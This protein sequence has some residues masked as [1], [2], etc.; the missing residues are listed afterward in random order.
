MRVP[1]DTSTK[2]FNE[3]FPNH[4]EA[5]QAAMEAS[6][7]SRPVTFIYFLNDECTCQGS[8]NLHKLRGIL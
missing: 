1:E 2:T 4:S 5:H 6:W 7:N 8:Y 3:R